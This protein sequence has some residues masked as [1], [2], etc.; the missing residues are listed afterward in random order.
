[1]ALEKRHCN[2]FLRETALK[3]NHKSAAKVSMG[4]SS[5]LETLRNHLLLV[6]VL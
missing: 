4:A 3:I 6:I 5:A 1:M 2:Y